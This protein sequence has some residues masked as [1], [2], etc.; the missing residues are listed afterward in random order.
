M[1]ISVLNL[2]FCIISMHAAVYDFTQDYYS[3]HEP[4]EV[5]K[6]LIIDMPSK[7]K[8]NNS[9]I[10][11]NP[12]NKSVNTLGDRAHVTEGE[13]V[14]L[15]YA[16]AYKRMNPE[17]SFEIFL[18]DGA[19]NYQVVF[20]DTQTRGMQKYSLKM[21]PKRV[22][23]TGCA[24]LL[25]SALTKAL[26]DKDFHVIGLDN[27]LCGK[28]SNLADIQ[29]HP[30]F[31]YYSHDITKPFDIE[32][33]LDMILHFASIPS[34]VMYY[35]MPLETLDVGLLGTLHTLDLAVQKNAR[36]LFAST[37]EVYGNPEV[38]PQPETYFGNV[39]PMGIRSQYDESK[40]GAETLIKLYFEKYGI[41]VRIARIFNTYGPGMRLSDGRVI[42]SFIESLLHDTPLTVHG[43]GQQT[44]SFA[45]VT[46]TVE[47][48]IKLLESNTL[49]CAPDIQD[50]VFNIGNPHEFTINELAE[51]VVKLGHETLDKKITVTHVPRFDSTDPELRRP[52]ISKAQALL[53]FKP[54]VSLADGLN[55]TLD[56][57]KNSQDYKE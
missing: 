23:I 52:D 17:S 11:N 22:L 36:Y 25:G 38:N 48:I 54:S 45:Y 1:K 57:F 50:R 44:R 6:F 39:D 27:G 31:Q 46:D 20:D 26:L 30:H 15:A 40:R 9:L 33:P 35:K 5:L 53:N 32:G 34:P 55:R 56:Y 8:D 21:V 13:R 12:L 37:S 41:D 3:G 47:G 24:G 4:L 16:C 2:T 7:L 29:D 49:S 43:T 19:A 42:T 18:K 14:L 10:F 51:A 28:K